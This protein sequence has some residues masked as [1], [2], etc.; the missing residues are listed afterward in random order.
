MLLRIETDGD[1]VGHEAYTNYKKEMP[2]EKI[3][4]YEYSTKVHVDLN[5]KKQIPINYKFL[6]R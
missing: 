6:N 5:L 3:E 1:F 4:N 2:L